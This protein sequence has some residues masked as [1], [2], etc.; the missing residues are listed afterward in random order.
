MFVTLD[1]VTL[2]CQRQGSEAG[3]PL[4]FVNSLGTDLRIWDALV[5]DFA[6]RY[7]VLRYDKRGHGLSDA[8]PGPYRIADH[9][10]DLQRLLAHFDIDGAFV[11]GV[12]VGGM[13][14][15]DLAARH[16]ERVAG[17]VLCDTGAKIG[18]PDFW[19]ARIQAIRERGLPAVAREIL[20]RWFAPSFA[21]REPAAYQGYYNMLSRTLEAGY[22]GTCAAI[23]DADLRAE[24]RSVEQPVL[25]LFGAADVSTPPSL[26]RE[27][28]DALPDARFEVIDDAGH[29]PCVEQPNALATRIK[30]FLQEHGYG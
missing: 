12:S 24:L 25:V 14:A 6:D 30:E 15:L 3:P 27:L 10:G 17:L 2:H 22:L 7:G 23:R 26:G 20:Q 21:K 29:L 5:T 1:A 19:N 11:V 18:V 13:I 8:P 9:S 4:V 28:A 16:P